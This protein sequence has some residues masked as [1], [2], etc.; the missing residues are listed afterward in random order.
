M[1]QKLDC[2]I[3]TAISSIA[4]AALFTVDKSE[5][6][7]E[8]TI[9]MFVSHYNDFLLQWWCAKCPTVHSQCSIDLVLTQEAT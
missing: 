9:S 2:Q 3:L 6:G 7:M 1:F 5:G 8:V 4:P